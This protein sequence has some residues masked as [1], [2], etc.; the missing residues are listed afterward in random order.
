MLD[1]ES[2][3]A[4]LDLFEEEFI[5]APRESQEA[6]MATIEE[7]F[8]FIYFLKSQ[9]RNLTDDEGQ[10]LIKKDYRVNLLV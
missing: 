7:L 4:V 10:S 8:M 2:P 9:L 3:Q 6:E 1:V 5:I